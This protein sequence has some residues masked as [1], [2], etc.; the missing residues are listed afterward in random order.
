MKNKSER[1]L[2]GAYARSTGQPCRAGA[3][4]SGKCRNHGG[5][6]TGPTSHAGRVKAFANLRQY[7]KLPAGELIERV[8]S[9]ED[10]KEL[11]TRKFEQW[12]KT[13]SAQWL[14]ETDRG[15]AEVRARR[16]QARLDEFELLVTAAPKSLAS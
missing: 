13:A 11:P 12:L 5:L 4:A 3:L 14:F 10:D 8:A 1:R 9:W 2:C 7:R 15:L 16:R 6:S